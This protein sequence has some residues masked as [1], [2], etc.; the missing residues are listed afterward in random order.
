[1]MI[2][3]QSLDLNKR[4]ICEIREHVPDHMPRGLGDRRA[5]ARAS[6][7]FFCERV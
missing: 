3:R 6:P 5:K 1:M 2:F 4:T 7:M